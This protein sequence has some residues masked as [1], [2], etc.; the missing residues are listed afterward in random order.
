MDWINKWRLYLNGPGHQYIWQWFGRIWQSSA[1]SFESNFT[2]TVRVFW[3]VVTVKGVGSMGPLECSFTF[4]LRYQSCWV[5]L[6]QLWDD[7]RLIWWNH[8]RAV[9]RPLDCML[10]HH[11]IWVCITYSILWFSS[12]Y[13]EFVW[14]GLPISQG[15]PD[16]TWTTNKH[17]HK[18]IARKQCSVFGHFLMLG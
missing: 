11:F 14:L 4:N 18:C 8:E 3:R 16:Q 17:K 12:G 15:I 1:S 6:L 5:Y 7:M 10:P 2:W 13:V 9:L